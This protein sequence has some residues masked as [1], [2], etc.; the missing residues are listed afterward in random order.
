MASPHVLFCKLLS[1]YHV[2]HAD[3]TILLPS[4]LSSDSTTLQCASLCHLNYNLI[5][6]KV[7]E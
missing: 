3:L 6:L 5:I 4:P 2:T 1:K 7:K